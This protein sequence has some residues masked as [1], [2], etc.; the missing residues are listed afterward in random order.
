VKQTQLSEHMKLEFRTEFFNLFNRVQ[1][2]DPGTSLGSP[3]FGIVPSA[4]NLPRLVQMGL[5][6]SF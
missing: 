4:M 2:A 1:F 3:Q 5:R 6:L